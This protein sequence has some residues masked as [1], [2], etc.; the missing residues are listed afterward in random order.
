MGSAALTLLR[1]SALLSRVAMLNIRSP[2][3]HVLESAMLS[4]GGELFMRSMARSPCNQCKAPQTTSCC[5]L[6]HGSN[7]PKRQDLA[8]PRQSTQL[9]SCA[10][11]GC[12]ILNV[13][14]SAVG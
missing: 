7:C 2:E 3:Q 9:G 1:A 10:E 12:E 4:S 11:I 6:C 13:T 14:R 5:R 8:Q